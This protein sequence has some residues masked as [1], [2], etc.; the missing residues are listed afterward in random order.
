MASGPPPVPVA[1]TNLQLFAQLRRQGWS[2]A[3]I[4]AVARAYA[5]A[6]ELVAGWYRP[7]GK[8]FVDH[9]VGTA[10][11]VAAQGGRLELVCAALVH[12]AYGGTF[13]DDHSPATRRRLR[14]RLVDELGPD[15]E[16]LVTAYSTFDW[17][18]ATVLALAER[19][20]SL[21]PVERDLVLLRLANEVDDRLD[22]GNLHADAPAVGSGP[23]IELAE[24]AGLG[25]IADELGRLTSEEQ[26]APPL[27]GASD[28]DRPFLHRPPVVRRR[29]RHARRWARRQGRRVRARVLASFRR[30]SGG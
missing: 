4:E 24:Q 30:V 26:A 8:P 5:L 22:L 29:V 16:V 10:S 1:Q 28:R 11:A 12:N 9:F 18:Q 15:A 14:R 3:D 6:C 2:P 25:G 19:A 20:G 13:A 27:P 23:L 21:T 7:S 17:D